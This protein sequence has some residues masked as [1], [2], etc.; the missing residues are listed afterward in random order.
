MTP[1]PVLRGRAAQLAESAW[2]CWASADFRL[3]AWFA[4]M[5]PFDAA[6]SR[7]REATTN[8]VV[9][10][11][12]SPA[13]T[14]VRT[15]RTAVF[16]DDLTD[17]L[18][19]RAASLVRL[20]LIWDLMLATPNMPSC[21]RGSLSCRPVSADPGRAGSDPHAHEGQDYHPGRSS[22]KRRLHGL[23]RRSGTAQVG[24]GGTAVRGQRRFDP[25]GRGAQPDQLDVIGSRRTVL[26]VDGRPDPVRG[27]LRDLG[28]NGGDD[29]VVA[30]GQDRVPHVAGQV[31]P[32]GEVGE[33]G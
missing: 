4:W 33:Q 30:G 14:A 6:W 26:L 9:A 32:G 22:P 21:R 18:R 16:R 1:P 10:V 19:S 11:S 31:T 23:L 28:R 15:R 17:L 24:A 12:T 25:A 7:L 29:D 20:R 8:S 3:A 2:T 5:M 13:A 27:S